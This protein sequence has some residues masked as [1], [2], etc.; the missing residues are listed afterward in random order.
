MKI[1]I[2]SRTPWNNSNSFGNTFSNLFEGMKNVEVYNVCCQNGEMRN[3]VV[4]GAFQMTDKAVLRSI[5]KRTSK[6]GW[7]MSQEGE[8][9]V[10]ELNQQVSAEAAKK[11]KITSLIIRDLIWKLGNWKKNPDFLRFLEEI[12]PDIIYL[13][14]YASLYMCSVQ[15]FV[16]RKLN[17]PVIGHISDDVYGRPPKAS[18]L[19]QWYRS[20]LKRVL[21]PLIKA[22]SYLEVFAENMQAEYSKI[23]NKTCYLIGKGVQADAIDNITT[24]LPNEALLHFVYTG[25]IADDRYKAL[26][27]IGN[28]INETFNNKKA[29]LDVYSATPLTNEMKE[30]FAQCECLNFHGRISGAEVLRVQQEA[31]F[32][33][34]VEGFSPQAIFSSKMSFSTKI[35]DYMLTG[36]PIL[37]YGPLDVNSIQVLKKNDIAL[38]VVSQNELKNILQSI[39]NSETEYERLTLNTKKYLMTFRDIKNIQNGIYERM[40][41]LIGD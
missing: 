12:N 27:D 13:P 37:A 7:V 10:N 39:D 15:S 5:Y 31:D 23:F 29:V 16:V 35:V 21:H 14:I 20:K 18:P 28:A 33:V 8:G 2:I 9:T 41:R 24:Q 30:A 25:N 19:E 40:R 26:I 17:I 1:L 22:C 3:A 6:T 11:R 4:K 38:T 34:H 36:K 32:L